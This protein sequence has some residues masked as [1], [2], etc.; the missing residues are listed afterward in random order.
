MERWF[1]EITRT[2]LRRGTFTSVPAL[3]H[4]T[5]HHRERGVARGAA[6]GLDDRDR[7]STEAFADSLHQPQ[8]RD[9]GEGACRDYKTL[10]A[11]LAQA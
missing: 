3:E 4:K 1:A 7:A 10:A 9:A 2:R 5:C 11:L 8:A 6:D